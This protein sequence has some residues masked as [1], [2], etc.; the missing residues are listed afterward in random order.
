VVGSTAAEGFMGAAAAGFMAAAAAAMA[1]A[2]TATAE[3]RP[4]LAPLNMGP[5]VLTPTSLP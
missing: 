1:A 4:A 5:C 3:P 2:G